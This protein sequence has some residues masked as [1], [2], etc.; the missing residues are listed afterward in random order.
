[1]TILAHLYAL[2]QSLDDIPKKIRMIFYLFQGKMKELDD[3]A[4]SLSRTIFHLLIE[5]WMLTH[6]VEFIDEIHG[7]K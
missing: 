5:S 2:E 7:N 6:D 1:M 3:L 4:V